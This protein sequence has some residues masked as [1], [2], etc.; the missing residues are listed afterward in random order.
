MDP[1]KSKASIAIRIH[2]F[3]TLCIGQAKLIESQQATTNL[4]GRGGVV[5]DF[6]GN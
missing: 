6:F 2:H 4:M 3:L 1:F 5:V